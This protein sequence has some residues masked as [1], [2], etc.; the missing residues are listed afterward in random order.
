MALSPIAIQLK[1]RQRIG[2]YHFHGK[3]SYQIRNFSVEI[4]SHLR[5][6]TNLIYRIG[7]KK[8]VLKILK[9]A[10]PKKSSQVLT[11]QVTERPIAPADTTDEEDDNS[12]L[13]GDV[14]AQVEDK[15]GKRA[16]TYEMAKN[17]GLTPKRSKEQR[18]PRVKHRNKFRKANI[19]RRGQVSSTFYLF[20]PV[21]SAI[22]NPTRE[23]LHAWVVLRKEN[24]SC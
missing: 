6:C 17:K 21:N 19:R 14:A 13:E 12:E 20:R 10:A 24:L 15:S 7:K 5:V 3:I 22:D 11:P 4:A 8:K 18:N 1:G 16:I 2:G 23:I 9:K